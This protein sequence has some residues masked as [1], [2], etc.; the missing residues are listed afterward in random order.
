[1]GRVYRATDTHLGREVAV[2]VLPDAFA[3]DP[4]RLTRFEREAR[5]LASLN[6]PN[7]ATIHGLEDGPNEGGHVVRAL[8]MEL[9]EGP[10]LDE[11]IAQGPMP[12]DDALSIARQIAEAL[13]AAHDHG[14]VHR[15]L[16]PANV[17]VRD[18][19]TVKVLDFGLAKALEPSTAISGISLSPTITSPAMTQAGVILGTAAYMS[20]EQARGKPVDRRADIWAFGCVLFEMLAGR[21][22]FPEEDTVSDT[23]AGI[24]KGEPA[25]GVLPAG[26]PPTI[27]ALL[28]RCLRKDVR[29][30]LPHIADARIEIEDAISGPAVSLPSSARLRDERRYVWP[31][32]TLTSLLAAAALA[33]WTAFTPP[34]DRPVARF[35]VTAPPGAIPLGFQGRTMEAGEPISPDGRSLAFVSAA[36]G[37]PA[38]WV[39]RLDSSTPRRLSRTENAFRPVWSPD[40]RSLI[41][42]A[43]GQVKRIAVDGGPPTVVCNEDPRD[44]AW[45]PE[46]VILMGGQNTP[47][48]RV[49]ADGG[50]PTPV[51]ELGPGET[52]HDYPH[53]LP[54]GR[55]FVYLARRGQNAEDWD[56]YVGSLDSKERRLLK[57][58]HSGVRYSRTG[59][60]LFSQGP[61]LMAQP[62]DLDRLELTGDAFQAGDGI[63][64]GVRPSFS[65]STS[66]SLAYLV[67]VSN[68]DSQLTWV[69]RSGKPLAAVG[70]PGAYERIDLSPDGTVVAFTR[71]LEILLF[72]LQRDLITRFVTH[73]AADFAPVFSPDGR[74]IAFAS[75]REPATNAASTNINAGH[76]YVRS[77]GVVEEE[78]VV[79][80]SDSGK[81][82]TDWSRDGYLAYTSENDI[83]ALRLP[84]ADGA[85]PLQVTDT[86]F[87]ESGARFSPDGRWIAYQ[88]TDSATGLDVYIRSF[89]DGRRRYPVSAGGG[90]LP[91]WGADGRVLFYVG[92]DR[93]LM[94]VNVTRAGD[95]LDVGRPVRLFQ[96]PAFHANG[97]Y[98]VASDGRFLL[99]VP[100]DDP[101]DTHIAVVLN[102][103]A[104][105][106]ED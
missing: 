8:V 68:P 56:V 45:S 20:P 78:T 98:E 59:H 16:K 97:E 104:G 43:D 96:S 67:A 25:W 87:L 44:L 71:A 42:I 64:G 85:T 29:R 15:D 72:D 83:W 106:G 101:T 81:T 24:L 21:R 103:A 99:N 28:E 35:D 63:L 89:P 66:G 55:H 105:I 47:L 88:S 84:V 33:A 53:F 26:T 31:A 34:P 50:E 73:P 86:T 11:R 61:A 58:L 69:D 23:L 74:T 100:L 79:F 76:L 75:S 4:E 94:S 65:V 30:R 41:F 80:K 14:V 18:D 40:S 36:G 37:T 60:L 90:S 27:R 10:T 62:F 38:I 91:R 49:S 3:H 93:T 19:G 9:V 51:T 70:R 13:E 92:P 2:K 17:K 102:W 12:V 48:L 46:N 52:T 54:D 6:H 5:T 22:P 32:V 77:L 1:M 39:R 82:P 95:E 7:I 57:G